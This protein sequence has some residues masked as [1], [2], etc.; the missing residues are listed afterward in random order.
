MQPYTECVVA[1]AKS[2]S[3]T[4]DNSQPVPPS[5]PLCKRKRCFEQ[6]L[7][8]LHQQ[9]ATDVQQLLT[10]QQQLLATQ[11]QLL[12]VRREELKLKKEELVMKKIK[13]IKSGLILTEDGNWVFP[14][15]RDEE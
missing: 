7:L 12:A 15:E 1:G 6:Q 10:V 5:E 3:S 11:Q 13:L 2:S 14:C 9:T 8:D 4:S